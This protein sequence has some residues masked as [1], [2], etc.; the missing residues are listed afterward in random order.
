MTARAWLPNLMPWGKRPGG[1]WSNGEFVSLRG[2]ET[3]PVEKE[4][5]DEVVFY[6]ESGD[7]WDGKEAAVMRLKDGRYVAYET[8]WGPTGDGFHEDA[9]GG[10]A[11]LYFGTNLN[12]LILTAL[13]D[14]GRRLCGIPEEG[15]G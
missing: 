3:G 11:N 1:P 6:G 2:T 10:D 9:Y 15:I 4:D 14:E 7:H 13:T 12:D 8:F 5:V